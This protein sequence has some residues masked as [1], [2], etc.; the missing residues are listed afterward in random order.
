MSDW[1]DSYL[2]SKHWRRTRLLLLLRANLDN[3]FNVI[4][5]QDRRCRMWFPLGLIEVHHKTYRRLWCERM[6]DLEVLCCGCHE[7]R[8]IGIRP[9]WW[10]SLKSQNARMVTKHT[11]LKLRGVEHVSV[12][13]SKLM[14]QLAEIGVAT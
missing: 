12:A 14:C 10:L 3:T 13:I 9:H 4:Q 11:Y 5:C 6:S 1:Y 2:R 7:Y 8:H